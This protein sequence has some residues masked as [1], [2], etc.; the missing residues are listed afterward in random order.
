MVQRRFV[1]IYTEDE[2]EGGFPTAETVE[3]PEDPAAIMK[4]DGSFGEGSQGQN[5]SGP[6]ILSGTGA[7]SAGLGE[8]GDFYVEKSEPR[9]YGPKANGAWGTGI[10]L[11][12]PQGDPGADGADGAPG[13]E[14][15][16]GPQGIQGIQG[17]Q[18]VAGADGADG[19]DGAQGP[20]GPDVWTY[21]K[22]AND[23][24]TSSG[25]A[26]DI[27]GLAF[28]PA[29]GK[30]YEFRG[31]LLLRTATTT[32]GPRPGIGWPTGTSDGAAKMRTPSSATADLIAGGNISGAILTA[33]GGL[34]TTTGSW[35]GQFEGTLVAGA[36]PSG[37]L[38]IRLASETAGT[39][40]TAKAGSWIAWREI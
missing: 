18:G 40:V 11:K 37:N 3:L 9:W 8:N 29:A 28:T 31:N 10:S 22:L 14:G 27:T 20:P 24:V 23:F 16:Q 36:S 32:V 38:Q 19:A 39:N 2:A 17:I 26:V 1:K 5:G 21:A 7:P 25:T 6:T 15:A 13:A 34:P 4:G 35:L 33:V 30:V 12:G